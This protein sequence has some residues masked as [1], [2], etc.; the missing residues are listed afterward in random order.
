MKN[1]P[2]KE[3]AVMSHRVRRREERHL[4]FFAKQQIHTTLRYPY[5]QR[6]P[7]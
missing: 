5:E 7:S 3:L 2:R 4:L 1:A 6:T